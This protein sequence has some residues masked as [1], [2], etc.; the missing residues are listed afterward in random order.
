MVAKFAN[1]M[2]PANPPFAGRG[3]NKQENLLPGYKTHPAVDEMRVE[4][5]IIVPLRRYSWY[6]RI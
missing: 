2:I 4:V 5:T 6:L 3:Y 1:S